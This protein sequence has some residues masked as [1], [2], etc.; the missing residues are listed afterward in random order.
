MGDELKNNIQV[1]KPY[2]KKW[3][4]WVIVVF[5]VLVFIGSLSGNQQTGKQQNPNNSNNL[6]TAQKSF[7]EQ[8]T[9]AIDS[10]NKLEN[11]DVSNIEKDELF[12]IAQSFLS[13]GEAINKA[14]TDTDKEIQDLGKEL[15]RKLIVVQTK[16]LPKMRK[17]YSEIMRKKLWEENIDVKII[18]SK[19]EILEL[20]G[21]VFANNKNIKA[22]NDPIYLSL[23]Q[24]RFDQVRYRWIENGDGSSLELE[25]PK[26]NEI[27]SKIE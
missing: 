7:K 18:G 23:K 4:F 17:T 10:L 3:W 6:Q 16:Q 2:Y 9:S 11:F 19:N 26:D 15:E 21:V 25:S 12:T 13:F 20:I 5:V 22:F 14:K 24:L 27:V 1:K 8:L